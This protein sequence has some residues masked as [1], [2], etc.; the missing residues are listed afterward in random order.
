MLASGRIFHSSHLGAD[1]DAAKVAWTKWGENVGA[2]PSVRPVEAAFMTSEHHREN[3]LDP[4]YEAVG[5]GVAKAT[6]GRVYVT[7][8]FARASAPTRACP[9]SLLA[10]DHTRVAP[11][12]YGLSC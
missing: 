12:Y 9:R 2:G 4:S 1:L 7:Q 6:D 11:T 10:E 8:V 5:V 3:I